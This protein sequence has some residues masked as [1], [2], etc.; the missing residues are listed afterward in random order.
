MSVEWESKV[1]SL[2]EE[3]NLSYNCIANITRPLFHPN[4]SQEAE[5]HRI[6]RL[7]SKSN[8]VDHDS[9]VDLV[10]YDLENDDTSNSKEIEYK[11]DGTIAFKKVIA[12]TEGEVITPDI[13]MKAHNLDC[14][15]W[16][17]VSFKNNFWQTQ[18]KGGKKIVLYQSKIVVKPRVEEISLDTL[19]TH[20]N[21]FIPKSFATAKSSKPKHTNEIMYEV[22]ICDLHLG[23]LAW[24][25]D[26]GE[27]YN[28]KIAEERFNNIII[29]NIEHIKRIKPE[30]IVFV[31]C[32]DFF[33]ADGISETTTGGT[34]QDCDLRWQKLFMLGCDM[35]VNA[36]TNLQQYA[37]VESFYIAS[38]HSRQVEFYGLCYLYAWFRNNKNVTIHRNCKSRYYLQYGINM[39]GFSHSYYEKK[40]NLVG[41]MSVEQPQMWANTKYRE[42]H[43]GHYHCE[44][45]E[46]KNGVVLR[47]LPSMTGPDLY[48]YDSGYIGAFKRSYSF[49]WD[50]TK[51]LSEIIVTNTFI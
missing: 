47:W 38:N 18:A 3:Q 7:L 43:L 51:G 11:A 35:L 28:Y 33:N 16:Q 9:N 45:T 2:R 44:L 41:L 14:T 32:N 34:P 42:M 1:I 27:D 13:V 15:Q 30:K 17:V 31:W 20:F 4:I 19:H 29:S 12:I 8:N 48:H 26:C 5:K 46:E 36:I 22:N 50:K 21:N 25:S 37:P 6:R 49:V 24:A 23:K 10:N 40:T 39:I